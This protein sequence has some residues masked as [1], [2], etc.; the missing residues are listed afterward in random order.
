M[1]LYEFPDWVKNLNT[2]A[3]QY[4]TGLHQSLGMSPFEA[5]F[6]RAQYSQIEN[7]KVLRTSYDVD[8]DI[9]TWL[10]HRSLLEGERKLL[11]I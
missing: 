11:R 9:A 4:N 7:F 3:Y 6:C 2:Y 10:K 8:I 1:L 5:V